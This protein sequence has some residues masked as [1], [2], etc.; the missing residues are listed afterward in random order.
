MVRSVQFILSG[1]TLLSINAGARAE[2][3]LGSPFVDHAVL[4]RG[5][6]IKVWGTGPADAAVKVSLGGESTSG[7]ADAQ[8]R[9][10]VSLGEMKAGGPF[11]LMVTVGGEEAAADD[12]LVGDVW[13]C[14]GQSNMQFALRDSDDAKAAAADAGLHKQ[15]RLG[16]VNV[17]WKDRPQ[18][19]VD[20][21]WAA[22]SPESAMVFTAVGYFFADA[23]LA[24]PAM[25]G[26]PIG[27]L[28]SDLGGT[29]IESWLPKSSLG[30]FAPKELQSSMFG[31]GPALLYNGMIHPLSGMGVKGVVWYQG[32][33]NAGAPARYAKL[34]P[35]LFQ[36]WRETFDEPTL[37]FL[38]VQLPDYATDWGGYYW[39]WIRESQARAVA[40]TPGASL[41]VGLGT[42]DGWNLH[43]QGK[44][45]I[46][47]RAALLARAAVYGEPVH[48]RPPT[49]KAATVQGDSVR[50]TFDSAGGLTSGSEPVRGF[51]LAGADGVYRA[52]EGRLDGDEVVVSS[53]DVK[54]PK[55][56][57]Y[58]FTGVP[59]ATLT[60]D[61]GI[62]AAPFRTDDQPPSKGHGEAQRQQPGLV[63]RA[64]DY[65]LTLDGTGKISSLIVR[66][67]QFLSNAADQWGGTSFGN[68]ELPVVRL[69]GTDALFA[70]NNET[71]LRIELADTSM[72]WT[73][74][75]THPKEAVKFHIALSPAV[76][77]EGG[78]GTGGAVTLK[79]KG[80]TLAVTGIDRV[81]TFDD[82]AADAGKVLE[83][84]LPPGATKVIELKLDR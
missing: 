8:G 76:S 12:L 63:Y 28:E 37:P 54:Q 51:Q 14:A 41:I 59:R 57:R 13:L 80:A 43:P 21:K 35:I 61:A 3:A 38:V 65:R 67:Q 7:K 78:G 48:G 72:K 33:G 29:V 64:P 1:L 79:R 49:F 17:E 26:V 42:N 62:P 68:R 58:A 9:W 18:R 32:E 77:V 71:S 34:L 50:V 25:K 16:K 73:V 70:G 11:K 5:R 46:G 2:V 60:N 83:V 22:A 6:P 39:Q 56:V 20:V 36:T 31:I 47:R 84:D 66:N 24:D 19:A 27:I 10:S 53:P 55:T 69:L 45:E 44:R 40:A 75:N 81:T 4:Q 15:L 82:I 74:S 52:A 30:G 23:L